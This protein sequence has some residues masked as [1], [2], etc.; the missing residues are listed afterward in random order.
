MQ[1]DA[2]VAA[3]TAKAVVRVATKQKNAAHRAAFFFLFPQPSQLLLN[4]S[5]LGFGIGFLLAFLVDHGGGSAM[6]EVFV[7]EFYCLF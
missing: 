1:A 5:N 6:H 4:H 3:V 2:P 7:G